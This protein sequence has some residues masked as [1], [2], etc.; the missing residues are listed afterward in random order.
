MNEEQLAAFESIKAGKNV[1]VTGPA[2]TGKSYA[3]G[4]YVKWARSAGKIVGIT[5]PTGSAAV[6]IGGRTIHSYLGIGLG[7]K[8]AVE[9]A[10]WVIRKAPIIAARLRVLSMLVIEEVSMLDAELFDKISEFLSIIRSNDAPMGGIQMVLLGD[11]FQLRPPGG[12]Y[13][14]DSAVWKRLGLEVIT[15]EKIMRQKDDIEFQVMLNELRRG[16]CTKQTWKLLRKMVKEAT[17]DDGNSSSSVV[18]PT[19]LFAKNVDVDYINQKKFDRLVEKGAKVQKYAASYSND[20]AKRWGAS[21]KIQEEVS[22]CVGAQVVCNWNISQDEGIVNGTRGI[23]KRFTMEGVVL[24]L[25]C[26]KEVVISYINVTEDSNVRNVISF[27][28]LKL[29]WALTIHKSQGMTLDHV[30]LSLEDVFEYGQ[31]YVALSRARNLA[32]VKLLS[33]AEDSFKAH[34]D[35][36]K[37][38]DSCV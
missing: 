30:V 16:K 8:P 13:C 27:M 14:F 23:I 10:N 9:L 19:V 36:I 29:A 12:R 6:L 35:V 33:V 3:L 5:A 21:C 32:S 28:P 24:E 22:L 20:N 37:F 2:G 7:Q 4:E 1:F 31:A 17:K 38:Y 25:K 18:R 15:F 34:P 26:G 11:F